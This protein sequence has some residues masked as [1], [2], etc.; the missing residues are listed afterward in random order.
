MHKFMWYNDSNSKAYLKPAK[1]SKVKQ[2]AAFAFGSLLLALPIAAVVF[3][4]YK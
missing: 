3:Q 2:L 4:E 1:E